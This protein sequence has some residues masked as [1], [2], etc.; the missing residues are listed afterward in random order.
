[1]VWIFY[2]SRHRHPFRFK[3]QHEVRRLNSSAT[4][5]YAKVW[6]VV[7]IFFSESLLLPSRQ[8]GRP[9]LQE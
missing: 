9:G 1:M 8:G 2:V 5:A 7:K 3:M 6:N 4:E